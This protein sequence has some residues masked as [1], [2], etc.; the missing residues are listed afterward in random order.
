MA[1]AGLV[2]VYKIWRGMEELRPPEYE[3]LVVPGSLPPDDSSYVHFWNIRSKYQFSEKWSESTNR[4]VSQL[5]S[6]LQSDD[7][8]PLLIVPSG[9]LV[10]RRVKQRHNRFVFVTVAY[11]SQA[12][13]EAYIKSIEPKR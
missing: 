11:Q 8:G 6:D 9:Q 10:F 4:S 7:Y 2:L 5:I 3:Y 13:W 1:A 12:D